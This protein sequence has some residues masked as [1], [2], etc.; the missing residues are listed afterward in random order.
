MNLQLRDMELAV[1]CTLTQIPSLIR[2]RK[3]LKFMHQLRRSNDIIHSTKSAPKACNT[4][5]MLYLQ[6]LAFSHTVYTDKSLPNDWLSMNFYQNFNQKNLYFK[7]FSNQNYKIGKNKISE[8]MKIFNY[9]IPLK[10]L[11]LTKEQFKIRFKILF[12]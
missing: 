6:A 8:R 10:W 12:L 4:L 9:K 1:S 11:N 2:I 7:C 3:S 5:P